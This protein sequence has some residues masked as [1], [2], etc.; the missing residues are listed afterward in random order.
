MSKYDI[1]KYFLKFAK[2][3]SEEFNFK[4]NKTHTDHRLSNVTALD[5][6]N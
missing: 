6:N 4:W 2:I 3:L 1:P 5:L